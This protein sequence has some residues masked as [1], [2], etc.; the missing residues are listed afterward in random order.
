M[1]RNISFAFTLIELLVV[2][3]IIVVLASLLSPAARL[4]YKEAQERRAAAVVGS[5][6]TAI[7]MYY[8]DY[9]SLPSTAGWPAALV[10]TTSNYGPYMDTKDYNASSG[11]FIDPWGSA[12]RYSNSSSRAYNV[13]SLGPDKSTGTSDDIG[14]W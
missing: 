13:W 12:Y 9:G 10:S 3:C 1:K 14:S 2:I 7:N 4:A 11:N 8:T 6:A 5:L